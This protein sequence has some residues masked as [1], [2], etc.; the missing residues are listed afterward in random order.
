[1]KYLLTLAL[2]VCLFVSAHGQDQAN[3]LQG[4]WKIKSFNYDGKQNTSEKFPTSRYK[5]YTPTHFAVI[6]IDTASGQVTTSILGTYQITDGVYSE[7]ILNVNKASAFMIGK[8]FSFKLTSD[9]PESLTYVGSFNGINSTEVW[10]KVTKIPSVKTRSAS[11]P[12]YVL[13]NGTERIVLKNIS[14][15]DNSPL[16]LIA[17]ESI[18][19][20]EVLKDATATELYGPAGKNGVIVI[21]VT[22]TERANTVKKLKAAGLID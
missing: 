21:T 3:L 13:Q 2:S 7:T 1:M 14:E 17:Q 11:S 4:T 15:N 5:L 16:K 18:A 19:S 8:T 20:I 10:E 6:E 22:E 9:A 12:L